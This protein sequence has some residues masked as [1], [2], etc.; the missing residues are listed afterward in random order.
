[1]FRQYIGL[2]IVGQLVKD[3]K[4][5]EAKEVVQ[6]LEGLIKEQIELTPLL[7][8]KLYIDIF[9]GNINENTLQIID[10]AIDNYEGEDPSRIIT[11]IRTLSRFVNE[12]KAKLIENKLNLKKFSITKKFGSNILTDL[13]NIEKALLFIYT[14]ADSSSILKMA[15]DSVINRFFP[16][17]K[18]CPKIIDR[19]RNFK[20]KISTIKIDEYDK[21]SFVAPL[22]KKI[23]S[24]ILNDISNVYKKTEEEHFNTNPFFQNFSPELNFNVGVGDKIL[25]Q[26]KLNNNEL[27][28]LTYFKLIII[29]KNKNTFIYDLVD[30][31]INVEKNNIRIDEVL[32]GEKKTD[33]ITFLLRDKLSDKILLFSSSSYFTPQFGNRE[34][35]ANILNLLWIRAINNILIYLNLKSFNNNLSLLENYLD[36]IGITSS[37][38]PPSNE[39]KSSEDVE[40]LDK[41]SSDV[42]FIN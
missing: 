42:E 13:D 20:S 16:L 23:E 32:A 18:S 10:K 37:K 9:S 21:F 30:D 25:V 3:K 33:Q 41:P 26:C 12:E 34:K 29:D 15:P 31:F 22:I 35:H 8:C 39:S 27:I 40:F 28:T 17:Y 2:D 4:I 36:F 24:G 1:M 5:D 38:N 11:V 7:M 6:F 14:N 19:I